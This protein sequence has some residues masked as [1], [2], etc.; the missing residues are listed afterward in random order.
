VLPEVLPTED[1]TSTELANDD[2]LIDEEPVIDNEAIDDLFTNF[3][4][5]LLDDLMAV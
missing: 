1:D 3:D 5:L 4:E 2:V